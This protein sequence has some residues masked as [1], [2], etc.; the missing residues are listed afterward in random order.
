VCQVSS[1]RIVYCLFIALKIALFL[2]RKYTGFLKFKTYIICS[3]FLL[4]VAIIMTT[5]I[6]NT[7]S[8]FSFLLLKG[9]FFDD[10]VIDY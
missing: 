4:S 7:L 3:E 1:G 5:T 10:V 6:G 8:E 9:L 2:Q